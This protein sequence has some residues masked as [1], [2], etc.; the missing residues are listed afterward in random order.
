MKM[1]SIADNFQATT[2]SEHPKKVISTR[3][4]RSQMIKIFIIVL[5][6]A[7]SVV[8]TIIDVVV[9]AQSL[10]QKHKLKENIAHGI[11]VSLIIHNLQN[12]RSQTSMFLV[13]KAW[14]TS[15]NALKLRKVNCLSIIFIG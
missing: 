10:K 13:S 6:T 11:E 3:N 1:T 8:F 9:T 15:C 7:I 14:N 2:P 12:E 4:K 5:V